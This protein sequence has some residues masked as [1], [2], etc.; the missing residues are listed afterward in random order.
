MLHNNVQSQAGT[1]IVNECMTYHRKDAWTLLYAEHLDTI[2]HIAKME[3]VV[4]EYS[5]L[6]K[7]EKRKRTTTARFIE[8]VQYNQLH[9]NLI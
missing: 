7:L 1:L 9:A 5:Y 6:W 4:S 3:D 8:S 2:S